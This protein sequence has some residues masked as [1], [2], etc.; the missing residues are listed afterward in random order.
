M[1]QRVND[2]LLSRSILFGRQA[3][4]SKF[5][6][7]SFFAL[8]I[9]AALVNG[10]LSYVGLSHGSLAEF[11]TAAGHEKPKGPG[12]LPEADKV[13]LREIE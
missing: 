8:I 10:A 1:A 4:G 3:R 13:G 9:L 11:A 5:A 6:V 7:L 2:R 12:G